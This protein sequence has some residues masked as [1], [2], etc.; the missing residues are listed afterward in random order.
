MVERVVPV[1]G[2]T[3]TGGAG[4]SSFTDELIRSFTSDFPDKKIAILSMT[5][6]D[7]ERVVHSSATAFE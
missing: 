3:G 4:K 7:V 2:I 6:Q 5:L 1:I